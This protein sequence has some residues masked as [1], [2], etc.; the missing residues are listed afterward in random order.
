MNNTVLVVEDDPNLILSI[1]MILEMG[2]IHV[3]KAR[4]GQEALEVLEAEKPG[5]ILLDMKMPVMDGWEFSKKFSSKYGRS[6]PIM[7]LTAAEDAKKRAEEI[8]AEDYLSKPFQIDEL[9]SKVGR[10]VNVGKF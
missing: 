7:V 1:E 8:Q 2:G 9:L 6:I 4:H 10:Y 5:L 3:L